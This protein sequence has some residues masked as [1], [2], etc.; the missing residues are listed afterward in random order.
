MKRGAEKYDSEFRQKVKAMYLRTRSLAAVYREL[1]RQG[2]KPP[3]QKTLRRWMEEEQWRDE[4]NLR[5][6]LTE[7]E[8]DPNNDELEVLVKNQRAMIKIALTEIAAKQPDGTIKIMNADPQK[9]HAYNR[10]AETLARMIQ[11]KRLIDKEK[12]EE[13]PVEII[14]SALM[15]HPVL[16]KH[17]AKP[18][19]RADV[20]HLIAQE[21]L[22]RARKAVGQG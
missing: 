10:L 13:T 15:K 1:K 9:L 5:D 3:D 4:L 14:F 18:A 20:R 7:A 2:H 22:Q 21:M 11:I 6:K 17:L 12:T 8:N 16:G 19:V